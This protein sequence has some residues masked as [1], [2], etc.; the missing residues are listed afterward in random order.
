MPLTRHTPWLRLPALR[1]WSVVTVFLLL[2]LSPFAILA[3]RWCVAVLSGDGSALA[4]VLPSGRSLSLLLNSLAL[5]AAVAGLSAAL[6]TALAVWLEGRGAVRRVIGTLYLIPLLIPPYIHALEWMAVVGRRQLLDRLVSAVPVPLDVSLS[7]Y[8]FWPA[9]LVLTMALFPIVT[10]FVRRGLRAIQPELVDAGLLVG[11]SWRIWWRV[12]L[13]LLA[14]SIVAAA[15]LVFVMAM[16]EYGVP[17]L[18]QCNVF[19]MEVYASFSQHF[20]PVRAFAA[21]LPLAVMTTVIL[22]LSHSGLKSSPLSSRAA[23]TPLLDTETWPAPA[24]AFLTL[25]AAVWSAAVLVPVFI[26]LVRGGSPAAVR[27]AA[28][29]GAD[30]LIR[31]VAVAAITGLVATVIAVP[32][33]LSF[34]RRMTGFRWLVLALPLAIPA[35]LTAIALIYIWNR[36][37]LAWGYGTLLVLVLAHLARFLPFAAFAAFSGVR[38]VDPIFFEAAALFDVDRRRRFL[39]V[40]LPV[41]LPT[42]IVTWLITFLLSLGELGA[43]LLTAPPGKATAPLVVYNLLHYG[44]TETVSA[45]AFLILLVAGGVSTAVLVMRGRLSDKSL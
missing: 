39:R 38:N 29:V 20:D 5:G 36:P 44:A 13:P 14:P 34:V 19:V 18:L 11:A 33:A 21:T 27:Q 10:L 28:A 42:I 22:A 35:P 15:G 37:A 32:L 25:A 43:S 41:L 3:G 23:S 17:S 6:G 12:L 8:G 40:T 24:R 2:V 1:R 45:L 30:E 31:T 9:V 7:A 4:D 26:L 16:V